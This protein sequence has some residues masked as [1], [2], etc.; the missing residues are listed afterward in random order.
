MSQ[1]S[2]RKSLESK[3]FN[4]RIINEI[5][6]LASLSN[7]GQ[8]VDI[9]GFVGII[10]LA[11]TV[12]DLWSVKNGNKLVPIKLL[13]KSQ[14]QILKNTTVKLITKDEMNPNTKNMIVYQ[15]EN[16]EEI[17]DNS[18]DYV[19]VSFPIHDKID[20]SFYMD[21][22]AFDEMKKLKMQLTNT[23][24]ISGKV[25]LF[26]NLP[27]NKRIQLHS[28][29]KDV[30]YRCISVQLPTDYNKKKDF[31]LYLK[32]EDKI[33][34]IFS[35]KN[36]DSKTFDEIFESGY[37][38]VTSIPWLAYPKY[39]ENPESS[40]IPAIILDSEERSRVFYSNAI[41]WSSSCMEICCIQSRN[42]AL[43]IANKD[44]QL[45]NPKRKRFFMNPILKSR[46]YEKYLHLFAGI[47]SV[48]S[49]GAFI[50]AVVVRQFG[51]K[52]FNMV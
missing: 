14:A 7:Y 32:D 35:E 34:K 46:T 25:K 38:L 20:K 29:D 28:V 26:P 19:I 15:T 42:I 40:T 21:F 52:I 48:F 18:F 49:I 45:V 27:V 3:E 12:G 41:E 23:Y 37:K 47:L 33:Y 51:K 4:D 11:G 50:L 16:K 17:T 24:I 2:L 5:S 6:S 22:N 31:D 1:T 9:N 10:S 43:L 30:P 36:L 13:E 44:K 39:D 8:S